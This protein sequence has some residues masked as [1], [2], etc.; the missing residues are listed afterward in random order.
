MKERDPHDAP[1]N[2][3]ELHQEIPRRFESTAASAISLMI[4]EDHV[5]RGGVIKFPS[6]GV[7]LT[8]ADLQKTT[9]ENS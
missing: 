5:R 6:L 9:H 4:A 8:S 1:G 3:A 2:N 7:V